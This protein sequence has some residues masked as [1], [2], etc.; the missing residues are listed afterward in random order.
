MLA[1][2]SLFALFFS[3]ALFVVSSADKLDNILYNEYS[4]ASNASLLWGPYRPNV[5]LGIRPRIPL[6]LISGFVWFNA[7]D[8]SGISNA[9][10]FCNQHD[11]LNSFGWTNY[12][13]RIGGTEFISDNNAKLNLTF[14]FIKTPNG[15]NWGVKVKGVPFNNDKNTISSIV[16]YTGLQG[17]GEISLSNKPEDKGYTRPIHIKGSTPELGQFHLTV[18]NGPK[19][20]VHP[21]SRHPIEKLLTSTKTHHM[22]LKIP[23]EFL[24]KAKD[25]FYTL[26]QQSAEKLGESYQK[27]NVE[28]A[29]AHNIFTLRNLEGYTGNL[30]FVQ[31]TFKGEFEF[32]VL[33]NTIG[34][35]SEDEKLDDKKL[36]K[37]SE[38]ALEKFK[39]KF[40]LKFDLKYPYNND[41]HKRFGQELLS[42]LMGG[43][44]Y[45]YGDSIVDR[46]HEN[47][48]DEYEEEEDEEYNS[49]TNNEKK[50]PT[51]EPPHELYSSVPS[52]PFF[53]RGFYWDEGFHLIPILEY[54]LDQTLE[55]LRSW[56]S[57]IDN[58]GWIAREQILGPE[59]RNFVPEEFQ[60][61]YPHIANPPTLMIVFTSLLEKAKEQELKL[62]EQ[63]QI[64]EDFINLNDDILNQFKHFK[65]EDLG[66]AHMKY[67]SLLVN[68]AH[69]IYPKLQKHYEWFRQSQAGEITEWDREA[70]SNKEGYRWRG[71][72]E[73]HCLASGLDDYP[74][75]PDPNEAE[76]HVDLLSWIGVMTRSMRQIAQLLEKEEDEN[77][78]KDIEYS[79]QRNLDDLH[80]SEKDKTYCDLTLNDEDETE[81]ECHKG[82]I[83]IMPFLLELLAID[84]PHIKPLIETISNPEELFSPYG[85]R[86]LSKSD[87]YFRTAE[88]YWRSPIWINMNY[89]AL[90]SLKYYGEGSSDEEVQKL[91]AETYKQLRNNIVDNVYNQWINTGFAYEQYDESTGKGQGVRH[92][93]GW[94]SL[95]IMIMGMEPNLTI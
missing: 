48:Y 70:Y 58:N 16:F 23:D 17:A 30:H 94:T 77:N 24:W 74:R 18:T 19:T 80:W 40:D 1:M 87:E 64:N 5:Y 56:F 76:L 7:D 91:A 83:S 47:D 25:V 12:D 41:E 63:Q 92:F 2:F 62:K 32:D 90:K 43:V 86:S 61:Q 52:R 36:S 89:L 3:F 11:D 60:T 82:Y 22:S 35:E 65:Y 13:P 21:I 44:G 10:H 14:N 68:Y 15:K 46:T 72:T 34:D 59:A 49:I 6:S 28:M 88:N 78:Y 29:P 45:F 79:I 8:L 33:Y 71:R 53:P 93:L 69:E 51:V 42:N 37:L 84:S 55:I 31:K 39:Q 27:E 50:K 73:T 95:V 26:V 81:F 66:E 4:R 38:I 75:A 85:I 20:N 9:R 54:D 57:L 67:P